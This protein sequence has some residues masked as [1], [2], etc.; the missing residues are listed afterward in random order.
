MLSAADIAPA[1]AVGETM[2][3]RGSWHGTLVVVFAIGVGW[4]GY[5]GGRSM[6]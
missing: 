2:K 6:G 5:M 3:N 1:K 4:I